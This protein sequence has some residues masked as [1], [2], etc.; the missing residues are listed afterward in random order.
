[1]SDVHLGAVPSDTEAAFRRW[2]RHVKKSGSRLVINGDLFDF[3]FEYGKVVLREHVRVLALLAELV[4]SGLP[5]LI[6]GGNH[7]WWGS[8][9]LTEDLGLDFHRN[10]VRL[11]LQGRSVLLA[12][13]D[14]LGRGDLGYR[15]LRILLR[16]RPTRWLFRWLHPDLGASLARRVSRTRPAPGGPAGD[17]EPCNRRAGFLARWAA[18]RLEADPSLDMVALG[19]SHQPVVTEIGPGRYYVN[20]GDWVVHRTYVTINASGLPTLQTWDG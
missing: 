8:D 7:D 15:T 5:V 14:G 20:S 10:P 1:M 18:S 6:M 11:R 9:F 12:H 17:G 2:L 13:G 3:W 19:H 4:E 16:G